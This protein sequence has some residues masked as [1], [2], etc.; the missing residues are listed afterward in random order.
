MSGLPRQVKPK[1][2]VSV[3]L[4]LGFEF[5]RQKGSHAIYVRKS[6]KRRVVIPIHTGPLKPGTLHGILK[7]LE[8][9]SERFNEMR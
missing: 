1:E 2:V 8:L 7:E 3:A 4:R 6:D 5:K 9:S